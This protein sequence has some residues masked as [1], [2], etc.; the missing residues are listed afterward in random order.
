[1]DCTSQK[2]ASA[3]IT[4]L[5]IDD[6]DFFLHKGD[7]KDSLCYCYGWSISGLSHKCCCGTLLST[8]HA[9]ICHKGG[10]P[11]VQH[12]EIWDVSYNLLAEVCYNTCVELVLQ[13]LTGE[14]FQFRSANTQD[15]ARCNICAHGFWSRGQDALFN[16]RVF[17]P[18]ASFYR[19]TDLVSLYKMHDN[20]KKRESMETEYERLNI[21]CYA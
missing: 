7:F 10:Y 1:M 13:P 20:A 4:T 14:S 18:N 16:G 11:S 8:D 21:V 5:P 6:H 17:H 19:T 15:E 9:M 12:N 3:W 2:S